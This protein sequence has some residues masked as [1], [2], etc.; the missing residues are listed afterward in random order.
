[1]STPSL[2]R[3]AQPGRLR[4]LLLAK[5]GQRTCRH[6]Y[7]LVTFRGRMFLRCD[8]CPAET[9]GFQVY[10]PLRGGR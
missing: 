4:R 1:M 9:E 2:A 10:T 8:Y 7:R 6:F 5:L 3:A